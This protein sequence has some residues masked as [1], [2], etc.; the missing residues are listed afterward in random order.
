MALERFWNLERIGIHAAE[1]DETAIEYLQ[2]YQDNFI[3]FSDGKHCAK[4]PWKQDHQSLPSSYG[5]TKRRTEANIKRLSEDPF[6]LQK[7]AQIIEELER[8]GFIEKVAK[9]FQPSQQ[10][11]YIPHHGAKKDSLTTPIRLVYDCSCRQARESPSLNDCL[12]ST[13]TILNDLTAMLL[14]FRTHQYAVVTDIEKAFL[15]VSLHENDRDSTRLFWLSNPN[16]PEN[17]LITFRFKA[18]LFG[19]TCSPFILNAV[20]LKHLQMNSYVNAA[21]TL[22]RDLYVDDVLSSFAHEMEAL[23][24]FREAR[25]LMTTAGFNLRSWMSNTPRLRELAEA[26]GCLDHDTITKVLGM[27]WQAVTYDLSYAPLDIP[28]IENATK[29]SI[30]QYSSRI[31]DPLGLLSPVTV[32]AKILMQE[33]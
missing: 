29:R 20:L 32:R 12:E 17:P 14:R 15:N 3:S 27:R 16:D 2:N 19:A 18:V 10:V 24:Y 25:D 28:A 23:T 1:K 21:D 5:V 31:Y 11:H 9:E 6:I 22:K 30:L 33:I 8:R 7:Y 26:E 4:L 13:P